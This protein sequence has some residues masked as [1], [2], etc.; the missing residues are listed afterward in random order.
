MHSSLNVSW[1]VSHPYKITDKIIILYV[2]TLT[3]LDSTQEDKIF[4]PNA[5]KHSPYLICCNLCMQPLCNFQCCAQIS[6][7]CH[8]FRGF[9]NYSFLCDPILGKSDVHNC[10]AIKKNLN[11]LQAGGWPQHWKYITTFN[12]TILPLGVNKVV[13]MASS[14]I[15]IIS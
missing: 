7:H 6:E 14:N 15:C 12:G 5:S 8:R 9:I 3:F 13:K 10:S 11:L 4:W 1:Q 2:Q